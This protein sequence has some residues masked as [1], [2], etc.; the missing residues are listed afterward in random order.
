MHHTMDTNGGVEVQI[1]AFLTSTVDGVISFT[2]R[3]FYPW[4]KVPDIRA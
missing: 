2:P 1:H 3:P 4:G